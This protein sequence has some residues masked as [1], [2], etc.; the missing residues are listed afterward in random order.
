[1]RKILLSMAAVLMSIAANAQG[2]TSVGANIAI[3]PSSRWSN[4]TW[5]AKVLVANPGLEYGEWNDQN[6]KYNML[7]L[8]DGPAKD[9]NGN[10]WYEK[11]YDETTLTEDDYA[12]LPGTEFIMEH[13]FW[14]GCA[15]NLSEEDT[16][17][18]VRVIHEFV[19]E[20]VK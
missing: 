13:T 4:A 10:A 15:Q 16:E 19:K 1:M 14:V 7:V 11:D 18:T 17:K 20:K 6:P 5:K 12:K 9:A 2:I 8:E 3:V